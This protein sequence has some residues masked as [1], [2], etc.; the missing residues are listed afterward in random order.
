[1]ELPIKIE[2]IMFTES[3]EGYKFLLLK[4][5]LEDGGFWQPLTG[6]VEDGEKLE[7]CLLRELKEETSLSNPIAI[8]PNIWKFEWKKKEDTIIEFVYGVKLDPKVQIKINTEEHSEFKWCSF[9]EA[10]NLLGK[11]NNK[12][13][14]L[15]LNEVLK[16]Y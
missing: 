1:M 5:T 16:V 3:N 14:F 11:E 2:G 8:L 9:Q 15:K 10:T 7:E 12:T 13:A 6:T 4:R